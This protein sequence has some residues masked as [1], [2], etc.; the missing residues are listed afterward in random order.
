LDNIRAKG[1]EIQSTI[2]SFALSP[3]SNGYQLKTAIFDDLLKKYRDEADS[4]IRTARHISQTSARAGPWPSREGFNQPVLVDGNYPFLKQ[5]IPLCKN[6]KIEVGNMV[7]WPERTDDQ[8]V[9]ALVAT[10][11]STRK[12][13]RGDRERLK[14]KKKEEI[15]KNNR[16]SQENIAKIFLQAFDS[17]WF[18]LDPSFLSLVPKSVVWA[19]RMQE[20]YDHV[21]V[22]PCFSKI[23]YPNFY[24]NHE[25]TFFMDVHIALD[26]YVTT[27]QAQYKS[28]PFLA[29]RLVAERK[30][31]HPGYKFVYYGRD[32]I[33]LLSNLWN[34]PQPGWFSAWESNRGRALKYFK[35]VDLGEN[36]RLRELEK[37]FGRKLETRTNQAKKTLEST[38]NT[39]DVGAERLLALIII[40][41]I[42]PIESHAGDF[43]SWLLSA[44]G[45]SSPKDLGMLTMDLNLPPDAVMASVDKKIAR[46]REHLQK[47]ASL[48]TLR[49]RTTEVEQLLNRLEKI[50]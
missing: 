46:A 5:P 13:S 29:A 22:D 41:G 7:Y 49:P 30:F 45:L 31:E 35:P 32:S 25:P 40:L 37:D 48:T 10:T 18:K 34:G 20:Q 38:L 12:M 43:A 21:E 6:V 50:K 26:F 24:A 17:N 3:S 11:S 39:G 33:P 42:D 27:G 23:F 9:D 4:A 47:L 28:P 1:R 14:Q 16:L 8:Y 36:P 19:A 44:D 2:L 15:I